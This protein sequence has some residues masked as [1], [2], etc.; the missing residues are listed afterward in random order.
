MLVWHQTLCVL[1]LGNLIQYALRFA[2]T[3]YYRFFMQV[4]D[5]GQEDTEEET[6]LCAMLSDAS[7]SSLF[8]RKQ[9][10]L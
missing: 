9:E 3:G 1:F 6:Q 10:R 7:L 2:A 4:I 8:E 5:S